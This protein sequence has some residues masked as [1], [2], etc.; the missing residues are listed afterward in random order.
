M[1]GVGGVDDVGGFLRQRYGLRTDHKLSFVNRQL[2]SVAIVV[3]D[4]EGG[5]EGSRH[6][7]MP[8]GVSPTAI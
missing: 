2:Q 8:T 5:K 3:S 4:A 1:G 7:G 6:L